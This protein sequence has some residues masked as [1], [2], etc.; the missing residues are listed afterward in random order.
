MAL[1]QRTRILSNQRVDLLDYNNLENFVCADFKAIHKN[2]W[3]SENFVF[4]GFEATGTG[5]TDLSVALPGSSCVMGENDGTL[6]IG[7]SSLSNLTTNALTPSSTNYVELSIDQDTGGAD[8]RAFWDDTAQGGQGAEFSQIVDTFIF[9][10]A[11]F[12]I[13]TASFSGDSDKLPICEVDVNGAGVITEIRDSRNM[14]FRLGRANDT[15]YD[16]P[17]STRTEPANTSFTGADKDISRLKEL[18]D[19]LMSKLKEIGGTTYW[20]ED[21]GVS[22]IGAFRNAALSTI[23]AIGSNAAWSWDGSE[24]SLTDDSG[25]PLD[26]DVIAAI[27]LFDSIAN[28]ELTRM[29]GQDSSTTIAIADGEVLWVELPDPLADTSYDDIGVTSTNFRISSRG[30]V[31]NEDTTFWIAFREGSNLYIR[32]LGELEPGETAEISDNINENILNVIGI[33]SEVSDPNYSSTNYVT[34]NTDLVSAIGELDSTLGASVT[35]SNQ[36][37]NSKLIEGGTWSVVTVGSVNTLTWSADSYIQV[38]GTLKERNTISA[39][40]VDLEEGEVAYVTLN[41]DPGATDTLA[42]TVDTVDNVDITAD[43]L[44]VF[45]RGTSQGVLVGND[46]FLLK[47]KEFL[48]LDGA[49]AEINRYHGQLKVLPEEPRSTRVAISA[50]DILKLNGAQLSLTQV[51]LLLKFDGAVI[52]FE[53]GEVFEADGTTPFGGSVGFASQIAYADPITGSYLIDSAN[54]QQGQTFTPSSD[55]DLVRMTTSLARTTGVTGNVTMNIYATAAGLPTGP[56]LGSAAIDVTTL[57]EVPPSAYTTAVF[58]FGSPIPLTNGVQY[59]FVLSGGASGDIYA[60][61]VGPGL[62]AGGTRIASSDGGSSFIQVGSQDLNFE[63]FSAGAGAYDFT[64]ETIGAN[65][66]QWYSVSI[67]PDTA[68]ADNTINGQVL[69]LPADASNAVLANAPK[70]AFPS[71][72]INLANVFVQENGSGGIE[73]IDYANIIELGVGGSG[74][75]GNGDA[76]D[77]LTR[78]RERLMLSAFQLADPNIASVDEAT[79]LDPSSTATYDIPTGTFKFSASTA[80]TLLSLDHIDSLFLTEG[81]DIDFVELM[82]IFDIDGVDGSAT[83][84]VSR[85]GGNE[86]Q[87]VTMERIEDTDTFRG[88]LIFED[89]AANAFTQEYAVANATTVRVLDDSSAQQISQKFTVDD[90]TVYKN[91]INYI[92]KN[93]ANATG[94]YYV[95]IVKDDGGAPSTDESDIEFVSLAQEVSDL[96]VGVNTINLSE[97]VILVPGDYHMIIKTDLDYKTTY[98]GNN[99]YNISVSVDNTS[100]PTPNLRDFDGSTWSAEVADNTMVY[101]LEGRVLGLL[102]RIT[103]SATAGDK[104]LRSYAIFYDSEKGVEYSGSNGDQLLSDNFLGS[105]NSAV[106]R[107]QAGRGIFLRRPDGTLREITIDDDDNIVVYSV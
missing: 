34:Q 49:L 12:E 99:A 103:S 62:Y 90:T 80:Q 56:S 69:V 40:S 19:A 7:A 60:G 107:S 57:V 11:S 66:Y 98:A 24:L 86:F 51:N 73:N 10:G 77:D 78:Y 104:L 87:S 47:D 71:T 26:S 17:W 54:S 96:S 65:E 58:D 105:P 91:I 38:P 6:F 20:Y 44:Y 2:V 63:A 94:K 93:D 41:R 16:Y 85:D 76:N 67:L 100:G 81:K 45:A 21:A 84:E 15:E 70:A 89:E 29:D 4:S 30:N 88:K 101:R 31:P 46:C 72:G 27:R 55:F 25:A 5:T 106:D 53:T 74:S 43:D 32:G 39:A 37:R 3:A 92:N 97:S 33:P 95:M 48:E 79:Q 102:V 59:A 35:D 42:V 75:G 8:S 9:L 23:S 64:P 1:L 52:D 36:D 14:F 28:L 50:A 61:A 83:Y 22:L 18:F 13:N 68:N 82:A